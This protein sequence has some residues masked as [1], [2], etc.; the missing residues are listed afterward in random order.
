MSKVEQLEMEIQMLAPSEM[1]AFR[2]WFT[3][4]DSDQWDLQIED[5][6]HVGKLAGLA[7]QALIDHRSGHSISL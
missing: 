4:Y 3:Q 7:E 6:I 5:D 1:G 2:Q